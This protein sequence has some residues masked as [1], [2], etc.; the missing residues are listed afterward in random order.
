MDETMN[1]TVI[2]SAGPGSS[3]AWHALPVSDVLGLQGVDA[4]TG[5]PESEAAPRRERFGPNRFAEARPEPR[6]RAFVRQYQDVMQIVLLAAAIASFWPVKE[7]GTGLVLIVITVFNALLGMQQEGKAAAAVAALSKMM[8]V[9]AKVRRS[10]TLRE[11]PAEELVPGDVV[12]LDAGDVVPADGRIIA[13]ASLEIDESALTGE[14]VPVPKD[15]DAVA[16]VDTPLADRLDMAYMNTNV[17]RGSAT[18][19]VT[20]TG[21]D[22]EV[23]HIS[24]L[25]QGQEQTKTPLTRQ[26]DTLTSQILTIAGVALVASLG[27]NLA[28]GRTLKEVF[29]AS[30]A[31]A[32]AA[33]PE[34][35]PAVV[36][37][38]LSRGT[39]MLAGAG[40]IMKQLRSAETLGS[41][42]A[43]NSDKTGTLTLN[44]MTAVRLS[45][46]DRRYRVL[47]P[48]IR[49][50]GGSP[51]WRARV[52]SL[53]TPSCCR[54][55]WLLT[56]R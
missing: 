41:T 53:S 33:I 9:K 23:G 44:Q 49:P 26:L 46:P 6:W 56:R 20:A 47:A 15:P 11:V 35:L 36:T 29:A 25:L 51:G 21:M 10:G 2:A 19:V 54:W 22:S 13:A 50:T 38:I 27:M 18:V 32:V 12:A 34:E 39:Q 48:A 16:A 14:S 52:T 45:L 4:G 3:P 17:T 31:F 5:L 42:S 24:G 40:A 30:I 43:I 37:A 28:R 55:C 8:I 1:D 7:Y